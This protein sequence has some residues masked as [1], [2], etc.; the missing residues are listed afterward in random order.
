M[1]RL[2]TPP[3]R[4]LTPETSLGYDQVEFATNELGR[5]PYPWQEWLLIHAGELL[6]D[7]RPRFRIVIVMVARQNGKTEVPVILA[8]YWTFV[9]AVPLILG[10][11]TKLDYAQESWEKAITLA[12]A[13]PAIGPSLPP[14]RKWIRRANGSVRWDYEGS[15][16]LIAPADAEGGRSLTIHRLVMDELRQH[17]SYDAW[18]AAE[19]ATN[20]VRDAQIWCLSNAGDDSSVVLNEQRELALRYIETGEGDP[21]VGLFEWSAPEGSDPTDEAA[22]AMANPQYGRTKDPDVLLGKGAAAKA[23]GGLVLAGF[24]TEDMCLRVKHMD[25]AISAEGW[26]ACLDAGPMTKRNVALCVDVAPDGKHAT[27]AA[28]T[29]LTDGR[30]RVEVVASWESTAALRREL[31]GWLRRVRPRKLGWFPGGPAAAVATSMTT[32]KAQKGVVEEIRGE[33][34]DTCMGLADLVENGRLV[35]SGQELLDDHVAG[36]ERLWQGDKW[37]FTRKGVGHVD[38][39]YAAAGA[40]HLALLLPAPASP[41]EVVANKGTN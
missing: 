6:P 34:T 21:R 13:S 28:A 24:L 20:A 39:A 8:N 12:K 36:A 10:T 1:P 33:V 4:E 26:A 23:K 16:Y 11:S 29:K 32:L 27:L 38:A 3:L 35:H 5:T 9:E 40:V 31:P 18:N 41:P 15:R 17:K 22:L 19:P 30:V 2:W 25:P 14:D 37:R 7:G